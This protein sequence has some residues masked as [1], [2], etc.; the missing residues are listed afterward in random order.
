MDRGFWITSTIYLFLSSQMVNGFGIFGI[1]VDSGGVV[2][3][4][5][6]ICCIRFVVTMAENKI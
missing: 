6:E 5:S 3:F 2:G 1:V 4:L